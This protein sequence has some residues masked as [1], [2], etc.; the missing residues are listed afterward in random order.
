MQYGKHVFRPRLTLY[1]QL[2]QYQRAMESYRKGNAFR[3]AVELAR[4]SFPKEVRIC[5]VFLQ[6]LLVSGQWHIHWLLIK[7]AWLFRWL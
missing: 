1:A 3:K 7:H 5:A 6:L 4:A 2:G